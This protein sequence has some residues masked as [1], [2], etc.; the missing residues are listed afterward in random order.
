MTLRQKIEFLLR[1]LH[2]LTLA[3]TIL[4][5]GDILRNQKSNAAFLNKNP[6]FIPPPYTLAYDAYNHT[7]WQ[8]YYDTGQKHASMIAGLI[9]RHI[10]HKEIAIY[11]WGCG[12][13]RVIR[14]LKQIENYEKITLSG[15]DY[16]DK[17]IEWCQRTIESIDFSVNQL[18]PPLQYDEDTFDC[19]YA[20]SILTHLSESSHY[21]WIEELLRV[22]KPDGV[23]IFTSHGDRCANRLPK[24]L[25]TRYDAGEFVY[26]DHPKE[27]KKLFAAY[28]PK[29]F[30][31]T[32][33]KQCI[34]LEH[35]EDCEQY[36][37]EQD[38]WVIKKK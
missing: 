15:S 10:K 2:L 14:H 27:G 24:D 7:N 16:N 28:H 29:A 26:K 6:E 11:E 17:S 20:I 34:I 30:M 9:S 3:D 8:I 4:Q 38:I 31:N 37:I 36:Q 13:A 25:K 32:L 23:L 22:L 12:P 35:L 18:S 21:E 5:L 19:I 33:L 1:R